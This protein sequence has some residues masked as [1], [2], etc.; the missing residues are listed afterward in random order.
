MYIATAL[1]VRRDSKL[2]HQAARV[3]FEAN[4]FNDVTVTGCNWPEHVHVLT[5]ASGFSSYWFT[6]T[7]VAQAVVHVDDMTLVPRRTLHRLQMKKKQQILFV[8]DCLG[9]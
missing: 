1:I 3:G 2:V 7:I 4:H 5:K 8:S 6:L 9:A